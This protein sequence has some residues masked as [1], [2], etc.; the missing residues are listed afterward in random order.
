MLDSGCSDHIT[1]DIS[2]FHE[3]QRLPTTRTICLADGNTHISYVGIGTVNATTRVKGIERHII[4]RD[5]IHSPD[6]RGRFISIRKIGEKG[7]STT[8]IYDKATLSRDGIDIAEGQIVGQQYWLTLRASKPSVCA[9]QTETP[10]EVLHAQLGHLSW[11]T[12]QRL[13]NQVGPISKKV[14]STCEGCLLGKSTRRTFRESH[15]HKTKPFALLH[16][17]LAGPM[18]TRSIQGS[19]YYYILVDNYTRFKWVLFIQTK[20]QALEK[21]KTFLTFIVTQ[22]NTTVQA[23]RSNRGGETLS[24]E[25]IKFLEGKGINHQLTAPHTPQQNGVAERANCTVAEA[26]R[27]MLQGASMTNGFWECA[28]STAVHVRNRAPSRANDYMSP[29]ERLFGSAPDLSYL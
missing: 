18:R 24:T 12:L 16:M 25:F 7:I 23:V 17:D 4:L 19:F 21:F 29:H 8:F 3:Y 22:F 9:A 13:K 28:V 5:V 11:S 6:L 2:D 10:I 20:D 14:L 27:A 1:H 26:A 15:M